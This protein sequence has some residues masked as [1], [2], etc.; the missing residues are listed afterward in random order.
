MSLRTRAD[1]ALSMALR[2][3]APT[4]E[5]RVENG[6]TVPMR[7]GVELIADH[8]IPQCSA[9]IGTLLVRTA[10][11]DAPLTCTSETELDEVDS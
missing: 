4:N 2:L 10:M 8:Y 11:D 3:P 5:F 7:D 1:R 6:V 9:P